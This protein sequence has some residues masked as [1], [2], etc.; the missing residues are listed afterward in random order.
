MP[1]CFIDAVNAAVGPDHHLALGDGEED[2]FSWAPCQ[3]C[4]STLGGNRYLLNLIPNSGP[5]NDDTI[6]PLNVC[7]DCLDFHANGTEPEIWC[8]SC[9]ECSGPVHQHSQF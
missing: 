1:Q 6:I 9:A 2:Y 5:I 3:C 4:G 7:V 8:E